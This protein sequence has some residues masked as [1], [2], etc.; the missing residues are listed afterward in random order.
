MAPHFAVLAP[1]D[2]WAGPLEEAPDAVNAA[3]AEWLRERGLG[4]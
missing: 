3:L 1:V 4:R 2:G